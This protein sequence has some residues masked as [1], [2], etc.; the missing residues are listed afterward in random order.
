MKRKG[1]K[2]PPAPA[3]LLAL[4]ALT[5]GANNSCGSGVTD[6]E[7]GTIQ[8]HQVD[9]GDG[10]SVTL[11]VI[12]PEGSAADSRA[13]VIMAFPWGAGTSDLIRGLIMRYWDEEAPSRGY[14]VVGVE[15]LGSSLQNTASEIIPAVF[16]W[17]DENLSYDSEKVVATGAS[18]GGRGLFFAAVANPERYAA[19]LGMP[20]GYPGETGDLE[21]L[22][23][24][25]VWLLVGEGDSRWRDLAESTRDKFEALGGSV[26]VEVLD[27]QGHVLDVEES[28]LVDW[29]DEVLGR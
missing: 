9:Y 14:I 10:Q 26:T 19:L 13:P 24:K 18:N 4:L 2:W 23:A 12:E 17:M 15:V 1:M 28:V 29:T 5:I 25:P 8:A 22:A 27:G 21:P 11:H 16:D 3:F 6:P 7:P 20:G